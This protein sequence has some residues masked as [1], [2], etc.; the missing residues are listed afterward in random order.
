MKFHPLGDAA[1]RVDFGPG[2]GANAAAAQAARGWRRAGRDGIQDVVAAYSHVAVYY[3]PARFARPGG[4]PFAAV[5]ETLTRPAA[6]PV[7]TRLRRL[8]RRPAADAV[9]PVCCD[10]EHAPDL[11]A[12][13]AHCQ[14]D[15][16]RAL[17]LYFAADYTVGAVGF[18]PGF[19]YLLG[20]PAKLAMPRR[21]TPRP[22]VAPGSVGIGS[23]QTGIYPFPTPGGWNL[24]GRT[25][26]T[27]FDP[28]RKAPA[29][30]EVGD[31]VSFRRI[32]AAEF[33]AW[34]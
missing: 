6:T 1:V 26:L 15:A 13:A 12:W 23:A 11:A 33:L 31:T 18:A 8:R 19:P 21:G 2:A 4:S 34:K 20:L 24:I 3:D 30:L 27:L 28:G 16:E 22:A 32:S 17:K 5:C 9:I 7:R 25:P 14:L 29:L 10:G